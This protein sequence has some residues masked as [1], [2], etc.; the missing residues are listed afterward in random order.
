ML[1]KEAIQNSSNIEKKDGGYHPVI[2]FKNLNK[3]IPCKQNGRSALPEI[4]STTGP[5]PMQE[6]CLGLAQRISTKIFKVAIALLGQVSIQITNCL[7]DV[8]L[9]EACALTLSGDFHAT[10]KLLNLKFRKVN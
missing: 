10:K 6:F 5:L 2:N 3:F 1:E 4:S 9:M 8:F 7:D